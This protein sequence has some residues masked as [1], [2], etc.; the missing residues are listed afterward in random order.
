[1]SRTTPRVPYL[2]VIRSTRYFP[3]WLGQIISNLGD[4]LN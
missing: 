4:T 1:M 2:R 3:L